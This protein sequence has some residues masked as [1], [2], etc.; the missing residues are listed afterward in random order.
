VS[1]RTVIGLKE[2]P[3]GKNPRFADI[4]FPISGNVNRIEFLYALSNWRSALTAVLFRASLLI[5]TD[6][7]AVNDPVTTKGISGCLLG[8]RLGKMFRGAGGAIVLYYCLDGS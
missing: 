1:I 3:N 6:S 5:S 2:L 8:H 7:S 4:Q